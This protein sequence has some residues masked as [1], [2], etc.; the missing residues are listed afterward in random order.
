MF[1]QS[2]AYTFDEVTTS[3]LRFV[4]R[5][6]NENQFTSIYEIKIPGYEFPRL[7]LK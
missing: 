1:K 5:G 3:A 4:G 7:Q 6:N 2:N